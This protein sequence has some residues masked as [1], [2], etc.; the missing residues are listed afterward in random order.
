M[1]SPAP[2]CRL[3]IHGPD[4]AVLRS[5][6]LCGPGAPTIELVDRLARL[7][8]LLARRGQLLTIAEPCAELAELLSLAGLAA[9]VS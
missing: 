5:H 1:T 4:G 2:W 8:L 7:R 6:L 3:V 9:L